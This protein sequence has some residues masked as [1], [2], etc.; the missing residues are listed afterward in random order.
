MSEYTRRTVGEVVKGQRVAPD[1]AEMVLSTLHR[2]VR[3]RVRVI[4]EGAM[5]SCMALDAR[6]EDIANAELDRLV[7]KAK[8]KAEFAK[9]PAWQPADQKPESDAIIDGGAEAMP[10]DTL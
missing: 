7:S 9:I 10:W 1:L 3:R 5:L 4:V 2:E 6:I 8:I